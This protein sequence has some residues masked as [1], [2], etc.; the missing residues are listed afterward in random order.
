MEEAD[1]DEDEIEA[2]EEATAGAGLGEVAKDEGRSNGG[3]DA[4][5]TEG[6]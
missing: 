2:E 5:P 1:D 4:P 6:G 3:L